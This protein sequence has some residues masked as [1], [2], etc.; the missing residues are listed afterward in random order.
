MKGVPV[1]AVFRLLWRSNV[2]IT[3]RNVHLANRDIK[4]AAERVGT[5]ISALIN[6]FGNGR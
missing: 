5:A 2:C 3:L 4:T 1:S 6:V